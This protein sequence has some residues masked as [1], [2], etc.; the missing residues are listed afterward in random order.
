MLVLLSALL[1]TLLAQPAQA[2]P[3][4]PSSASALGSLYHDG[5]SPNI[6]NGTLGARGEEATPYFPAEIPSCQGES[7]RAALKIHG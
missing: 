5:F 1:F 4:A 3:I 6:T 7:I 2:I